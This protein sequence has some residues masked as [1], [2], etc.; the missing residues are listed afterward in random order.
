[1]LPL[2]RSACPT[3]LSYCGDEDD[4]DGDDGSGDVDRDDDATDGNADEQ[5]MMPGYGEEL[6]MGFNATSPSAIANSA[7]TNI[8]ESLQQGTLM[9]STSLRP[10][11]ANGPQLICTHYVEKKIC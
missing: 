3:L 10:I 11:Y 2:L 6:E 8:T 4:D 9:W 7:R 1:M 5:M